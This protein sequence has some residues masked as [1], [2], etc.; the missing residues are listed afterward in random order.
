MSALLAVVAALAA[1]QDGAVAI[2][3]ARIITVSG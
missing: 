2:K 1:A 3:G